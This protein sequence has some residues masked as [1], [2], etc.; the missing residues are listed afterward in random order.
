MAKANHVRIHLCINSAES[1]TPTGHAAAIEVLDRDGDIALSLMAIDLEGPVCRIDNRL[2]RVKLGYHWFHIKGHATWVGSW[3]WDSVLMEPSTAAELL[4]HARASR[5]WSL[6][7][8]F[9]TWWELWQ[10]DELFDAAF[11]TSDLAAVGVS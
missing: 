2:A 6:D 9:S 11:I 5:W 1:G 8:G 4:N 7:A 3:C 10:S